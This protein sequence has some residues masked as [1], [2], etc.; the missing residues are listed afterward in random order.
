MSRGNSKYH[1]YG[2]RVK[3]SSPLNQI[4]ED[5]AIP[6][7]SHAINPPKRLKSVYLDHEYK[8]S[9]ANV[10]SATPVNSEVHANN[11][12]SN[13][14]LTWSSQASITNSHSTSTSSTAS[15]VNHHQQQAV[16]M[17]T[18]NDQIASSTSPSI[19][20]A[21]SVTTTTTAT[22]TPTTITTTNSITATTTPICVNMS[23]ETEAK[24]QEFFKIINSLPNS[25]IITENIDLPD[26][27]NLD[28]IKKFE[29][30]YVNKCQVN[31]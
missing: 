9:Q 4:P 26:N 16:T 14:N 19:G 2:I 27:C 6:S 3:A 17:S 24:V 22:T 21:S 15:G 20:N 12:T 29:D 7:R 10:I 23:V 11:N 8:S 30:L 25:H 28:D 1:Y 13:N 18:A 5:H 31:N